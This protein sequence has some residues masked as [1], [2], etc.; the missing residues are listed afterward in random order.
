[1]GMLKGEAA[2]ITMRQALGAHIMAD[3]Y[4][5][6][7]PDNDE[8]AAYLRKQETFLRLKAR[9]WLSE[10]EAAR[11]SALA[12]TRLADEPPMRDALNRAREALSK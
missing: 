2:T 5:D 7:F 8:D 9:Q 11:C 12:K 6:T 1:M 3:A 4:R 10:A